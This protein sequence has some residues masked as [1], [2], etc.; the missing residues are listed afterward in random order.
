MME[1][2]IYYSERKELW[3]YTMEQDLHPGEL[4]IE[5]GS[6]FLGA[7]YRAGMLD[8]PG[9][10]KLVVNLAEFD[11]VTF[12]ETVLALAGCAASGKLLPSELQKRIKSIRYRQGKIDGYGSRLHYFTDWL[13][14]N[15][16]KKVLKDISRDLKGKPVRKKINF[17]T[18][19]SELY[20][21]LKNPAMVDSMRQIE[22]NLSRKTFHVIGKKAVNAIKAKIQS[23]DIIA[24]AAGQ[25]GLDVAHAGFAVRQGKSLRLLHAS[26]KEGAVAISKISL[27]AYLKANKNFT[28][29]I[30]ARF[31]RV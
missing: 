16:K 31:C 9:R 8:T 25:E 11:C 24:F 5:I 17:M 3:Q 23:G 28:G 1:T 29:I 7:P 19:H 2:E 6:F 21:A 14:D 26:S 10:E 15:E 12:V 30:V 27:A 18:S 4:I 22:K 13:R 20:A